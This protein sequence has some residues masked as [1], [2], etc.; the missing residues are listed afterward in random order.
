MLKVLEI[1]KISL[2]RKEK[3][4]QNSDQTTCETFQSGLCTVLQVTNP[5]TL[6]R[7]LLCHLQHKHL[8][9]AFLSSVYTVPSYTLYKRLRRLL[10]AYYE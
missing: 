7:L 9:Y 8:S 10:V 4:E 5:K 1:F 2:I 6:I 3:L